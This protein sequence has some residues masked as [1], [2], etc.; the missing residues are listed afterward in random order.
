MTAQWTA[1]LAPIASC[2]TDNSSF[3]ST[4]LTYTTAPLA[5]DTEVTG[6][7]T[8]TIWARITNATDATLV[9]VLSDVSPGGASNQLT[10]GFLLASQRAVDRSKATLSRD[11]QVI[12]PWHPFSIDSRKAVVPGEPTEYQIEIYPTSN[13]FKAGHRIRLTINTADT[14]A[15]LTTVPQ[16]LGELGGTL[17]VLHGPAHP[18]SVL[19]GLPGPGS[20]RR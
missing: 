13:V 8:A 12:R 6:P 11:G 17:E 9:G 7:V 20:S 15:T 18:S 2:E 3:E 14:P 4:A 5:K 19:L 1:G 16:L 10:A